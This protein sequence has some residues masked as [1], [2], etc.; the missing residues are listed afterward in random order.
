MKKSIVQGLNRL[1]LNEVCEMIA[2]AQPRLG[3]SSII[4][5]VNTF[6]ACEKI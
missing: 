2:V 4:A 5:A 6:L 1:D 3:L